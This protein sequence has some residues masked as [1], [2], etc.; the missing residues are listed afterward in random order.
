MVAVPT[1]A[2][3]LRSIRAWPRRTESSNWWH[4][5]RILGEQRGHLILVQLEHGAGGERL[6][7][8]AWG[9][10]VSMLISPI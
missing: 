3:T 10:P 5:V 2:A 6:H 9:A 4:Q 8:R 7:R 1:L